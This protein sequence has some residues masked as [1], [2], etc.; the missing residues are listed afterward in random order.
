MAKVIIKV[1]KAKI[2]TLDKLIDS[3]DVESI[4]IGER[5]ELANK[6][7]N[8]LSRI[9]DEISGQMVNCEDNSFKFD[10]KVKYIM[11]KAY[12]TQS[13]IFSNIE[14]MDLVGM[15]NHE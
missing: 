5:L 7:N 13:K 2:N 3:S 1:S 10:K 6:I 14:S 4:S 9:F 8:L 11:N 15:N 12:K